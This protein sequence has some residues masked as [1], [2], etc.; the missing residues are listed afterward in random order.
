MRDRE[1]L[2]GPVEE[3]GRLRGR[4]GRQ[5]PDEDK[6]DLRA[7]PDPPQSMSSPTA[8]IPEGDPEQGDFVVE[9]PVEDRFPVRGKRT[10]EIEPQPRNLEVHDGQR[11]SV[12]TPSIAPIAGP[13][14]LAGP[15]DRMVRS[16]LKCAHSLARRMASSRPNLPLAERTRPGRLSDLVGNPRARAQLIAFGESWARSRSPPAVRAALLSGPPGVGKTSSAL[17]LAHQFGWDVVEMNASDARNESAID[18]VAGR[19]SRTHPLTAGPVDAQRHRVLILLDEADC[20]T[21]RAGEERAR[22][23]PPLSLREFLRGRYGSIGELNRAWGLGE[24]GAPRPFPR[25]EAVPLSAGSAAWTRHPAAQADLREFGSRARPRDLTDRG[26]LGAILRLV[27]E[28]LQ[29]VILT[30]NNDQDLLRSSPTVRRS[31]ARIAFGPLL[32]GEMRATLGRIARSEGIAVPPETLDALVD[33]A[34]GDLRAGINDLEAMARSPPLAVGASPLV[35]HRD[36]A[37]DMEAL[38]RESL[39]SARFYRAVEVRERTDSAPDDLVPWVE[40]NLPRE[41]P[42]PRHGLAAF[43][44][45]LE[46]ERCLQRA[47]RYRTYG[48]WSYA[49]EI[50]TG[51]V[52]TALHDA[53][54]PP[55]APL[56]FPQYLGE[57][58]RSRA[59][60]ASRDSI[61]AK[62]G[63]HCHVSRR[64]ARDDFL[65]LMDSLFDASGIPLRPLPIRFLGLTAPEVGYLMRQSPESEEIAK[66]FEPETEPDPGLLS[67]RAD[68]PEPDIPPGEAPG[69]RTPPDLAPPEAAPGPSRKR[70]QRRLG[71]FAGGAP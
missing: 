12:H 30:V 26:G 59:A 18:E 2:A 69:A 17:A 47:R 23:P 67:R 57:M 42:D 65:L 56:R 19:A 46:G 37:G 5:H 14:G 11:T 21:G 4:A 20:L 8:R 32:P 3:A 41:A 40:E 55:P 60:R 43:E 62:I 51:G 71:E 27:R 58:G 64:K 44:M 36:R 70:V 35:G 54:V 29:P 50:L 52:G 22:S 13:G 28:T 34:Q 16:A 31:L 45:L 48:L 68:A 66:L 63:A 38:L 33:R 61:A 1:L 6:G 9:R 24:P 39:S 53:P 49:S 10:G 25:W 7:E 15:R